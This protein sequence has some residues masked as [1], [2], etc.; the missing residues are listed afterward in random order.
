MF[1]LQIPQLKFNSYNCHVLSK[2]TQSVGALLFGVPG[3]L[4][5]GLSLL[6]AVLLPVHFRPR[7]PWRDR[8]DWR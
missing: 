6:A 5:L 1:K 7:G 8:V 4:I 3:T 2:Q